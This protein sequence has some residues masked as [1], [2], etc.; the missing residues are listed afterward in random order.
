M[1]PINITGRSDKITHSQKEHAREKIQKLER[2]FSG[3]TRIEAVLEREA[4]R[5]RAELV[6][7]VKRGGRIVVHCDDKDLYAAIDLVL[8]K[9]ETQLTRHKGK[10]QAR[11]IHQKVDFETVSGGSDLDESLESYD[12]IVE[13]ENFE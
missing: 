11:R 4:E 10:R 13:R 9:A 7:S 5:C 8:D 3:I 6:I 1:V 2:Y 12:E